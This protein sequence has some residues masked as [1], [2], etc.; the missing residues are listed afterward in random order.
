MIRMA[1]VSIALLGLAAPS[2]AQPDYP[3]ECRVMEELVEA[4]DS[5][6]LDLD[7][8]ADLVIFDRGRI[9]ILRGNGDGTFEPWQELDEFLVQGGFVGDVDGDG[10][11]DIVAVAHGPAELVAWRLEPDDTFAP[12][13]MSATSITTLDGF[14]PA[15]LD[16]DGE[17]DLVYT[18]AGTLDIITRLGNGDGTFGPESAAASDRAYRALDVADVDADGRD[19]VVLG[20]HWTDEFELRLALPGGALGGPT[21]LSSQMTPLGSTSGDFDGNGTVDL[22]LVHETAPNARLLLGVG[23]GTFVDTGEIAS[24]LYAY[25]YQA[26]DADGDGDLDLASLGFERIAVHVNSGTGEF[27]L[28]ASGFGWGARLHPVELNGDGRPDLVAYLPELACTHLS[29]PDGGFGQNWEAATPE[30]FAERVAVGRASRDGYDDVAVICDQNSRVATYHGGPGSVTL[31]QTFP[32]NEASDLL[33]SDLDGDGDDELLV[34]ESDA[35]RVAV[36]WNLGGFLAAPVTFPVAPVPFAIAVG[37]LNEDG[38]P[39]IVA[40]SRSLNVL[41]VLLA[42]DGDTF[43]DAIDFPSMAVPTDLALADT[44]GDGHLDASVAGAAGIYVHFGF[45]TGVLA[46]PAQPFS[47]STA[48]LAAGD[49]S[50][51]GRAEIV[52]TG[53]SYSLVIVRSTGTTQFVVEPQ[54]SSE[55][56]QSLRLADLEGDGAL[57]VVFALESDRLVGVHTGNGD[58]TLASPTYYLARSPRS[59]DVGDVNGDSALDVVAIDWSSSTDRALTVLPRFTTVVGDPPMFLRGDTNQDGAVDI[60]DPVEL[61]GQL[62]AGISTTCVEASDANDDGTRDVADAVYL[63]SALFAGGTVPPTPYLICG[64]DPTVDL[65]SCSFH[66]ACP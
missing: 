1:L 5:A 62:F 40:A 25:D 10:D 59:I 6:D 29:T 30:W 21:L 17:I 66:S 45:G 34:A 22:V 46:S 58:G 19:D 44:N 56:A 55:E 61:L 50:G 32:V 7:G 15:D 60:A 64:M 26:V 65:L 38:R 48:S 9:T 54:S 23:D 43:A 31:D 4:V 13:A 16:G 3:V 57:D 28:G 36:F 12:F 39:D 24:S 42:L 2:A 11:E 18:H 14:S 27:A 47:T 35:H 8:L 63:L 51:D 52:A 37:D 20:S 53:P 33:W 41:S 49:L